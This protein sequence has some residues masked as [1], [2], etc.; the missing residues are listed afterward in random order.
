MRYIYYIIMILL[1]ISAIIGYELRSSRSNTKDA[2]III[3]DK[4]ITAD[5]FKKM[6]SSCPADLKETNDF[7]NSLVT[8]ELLI[9]ESQKEGIDKD[10]SFR[11]SIQNYYE[12][13]LIKS[14]MD[15]KYASLHITVSDEELNRYLAF[16][17][18]KFTLTLYSFSSQEEALSGNYM[19][20]ESK[21][22]NFDDL[23]GDMRD[24]IVA[25]KEGAVT[26]PFR[27]GGKYIVIKIDRIET[28]SSRPP[29]GT[30]KENIRNMLI[31]EKK[32]KIMNDW[33]ADLRKKAS[34]KVLITGKN[35]G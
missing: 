20:M 2:A 17:N 25:L 28:V 9:Q 11:K 10:E 12:Q 33:I 14:L 26:E 30:E 22:V 24:R 7:I 21:N 27:A 6:Y 32:E 35:Q 18:K 13:S 3:N 29:S 5:E 19:N 1:G 34:I 15:R 16:L 23:S 31:D 4:V 8:K